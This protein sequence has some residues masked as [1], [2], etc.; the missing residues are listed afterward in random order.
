[1]KYLQINYLIKACI[2]N[3]KW[4]NIDPCKIFQVCSRIAQV[5]EPFNKRESLLIQ[6][7]I[8]VEVKTDCKMVCME[9]WLRKL[10][11]LCFETVKAR[12]NAFEMLCL[13]RTLTI[14]LDKR[15]RH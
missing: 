10:E 5:E 9:V 6:S 11:G 14:P 12:L 4:R 2:M 3:L 15:R 13:R 7:Y 8:L 1:M